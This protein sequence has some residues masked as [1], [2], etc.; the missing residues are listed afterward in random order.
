MSD[1]INESASRRRL[2]TFMDKT[3]ERFVTE[4]LCEHCRRS[5]PEVATSARHL[6]MSNV[7]Q[8]PSWYESLRPESLWI[9]SSAEYNQDSMDEDSPEETE[10]GA[11][12]D[13]NEG[14]EFCKRFF[15]FTTQFIQL[16]E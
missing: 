1:D 6:S 15:T 13:T 4:L 9:S 10:D 8:Q 16:N 12:E 3:K 5:S 2:C 11:D 14:S 7:A